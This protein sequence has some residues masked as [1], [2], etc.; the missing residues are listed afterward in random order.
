MD[1][2]LPAQVRE[3]AGRVRPG[4]EGQDQRGPH[5]GLQLL[6]LVRSGG[7]VAKAP[8]GHKIDQYLNG[9]GSPMAGQGVDFVR[10]GSG[11]ASTP[12]CSS[13]IATIESGAG[14]AHEAPVQPVQLG[15]PP[16]A[17]R[18][19]RTG[20]DQRRGAWAE[21]GLH[22]PGSG[23]RR[24]RSSPSTPPPRT[25]TTRG[26]GPRSSSQVMGAVGGA[27]ATPY[28]GTPESPRPRLRAAG[29]TPVPGDARMRHR[30][31]PCSTRRSS[32]RRSSSA[33]CRGRGYTEGT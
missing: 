27:P 17:R 6:P 10:P 20:G 26:T 24:R 31:R 13:G 3:G 4:A 16:R 32:G 19:A 5:H 29:V 11:S 8:L 21:A 25:T 28:K 9:R 7:V 23:R 15:R 1:E 2:E 12:A 33:Y 22:R 30:P 18:S 14:A